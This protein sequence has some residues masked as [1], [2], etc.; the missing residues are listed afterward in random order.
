MCTRRN[1][2]ETASHRSYPY[3][4][5]E[6][7]RY[8]IATNTVYI[9]ISFRIDYWEEKNT[10]THTSNIVWKSHIKQFPTLAI[11]FFQTLLSREARFCPVK[12]ARLSKLHYLAEISPTAQRPQSSYDM[13]D[14]FWSMTT[15]PRVGAQSC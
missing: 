15:L 9:Y 2:T 1:P 7:F 4:N 13:R 3:R 11:T 10:H 6:I 14:Q 12:H 5:I 8:N